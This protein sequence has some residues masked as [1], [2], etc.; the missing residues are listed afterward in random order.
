MASYGEAP[1]QES[2]IKSALRFAL[3]S[4]AAGASVPRGL[5]GLQS[6]GMG[7]AAGLQRQEAAQQAAQA[8]AEKQLAAEQAREDRQL[9]A[10]Y[11]EAQMKAME[12]PAKVD[13]PKRTKADEIAE[14]EARV[15]RPAT[16]KEIAMFYGTYEKPDKPKEPE[17]KDVPSIKDYGA[18]QSNFVG[19]PTVKT[20]GKIRDS[21]QVIKESGKLASGFGDMAMI[22][23][24]AKSLDA[25]TGVKEQ[26]FNNASEAIG[27]LQKAYNAPSKW[28][29]GTRLTPQGRA[30]LLKSAESLYT[31]R[32]RSYDAT[33]KHYSRV[34]KKYGVDPTDII[35]DYGDDA[36]P[37]GGFDPE[38]TARKYGLD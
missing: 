16:D 34:A 26:E 28:F 9:R 13:T 19:E 38:A 12:K 2:G 37:A 10:R 15:K 22:T 36:A 18:I 5:G 4:I 30:E 20:F 3:N 17:K 32:K 8:Y 6:F 27:Y 29:S 24:Y 21:Y 11:M 33:A 31:T 23:A 1:Y 14:F 35:I 7:A 25:D